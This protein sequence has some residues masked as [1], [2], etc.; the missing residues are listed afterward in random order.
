M[1]DAYRDPLRKILCKYDDMWDGLLGE[2]NVVEHSI[3][4]NPG[5]KPVI[6][7]LT[8]HFHPPASLFPTDSGEL[9]TTSS[10]IQHNMSTHRPVWW[11]ERRM[12]IT[13]GIILRPF[14]TSTTYL[15]WMNQLT[16]LVM[17]LSSRLW[18]PTEDIIKYLLMIL[19]SIRQPS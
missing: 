9:Y 2:I 18:I 1:Q 17:Q 12:S 7:A 16:P 13:E 3:Y 10:S 5:A 14:K 15:S 11:S 4:I 8:E 19:T 6:Y